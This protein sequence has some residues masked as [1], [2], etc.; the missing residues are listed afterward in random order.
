M[1][2]RDAPHGSARSLLGED[3]AGLSLM[4]VGLKDIGEPT[5]TLFTIASLNRFLTK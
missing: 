1:S 4:S 5:R 2:N 3:G